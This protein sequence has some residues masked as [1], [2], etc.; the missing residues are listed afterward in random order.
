MAKKHPVTLGV[1]CL[2]R[3]TYD[4]QAAGEIYQK[5]KDDLRKIEAVNWVFIEELVIEVDEARSAA[6]ALAAKN[7]DGFVC[8]SGTFHL[9]HLVLEIEK[10]LHKP[11]LL[12]AW[13]ELPYNGGKIR[14]NSLCGLNLNASNL[15]KACVRN[16]HMC[17]ANKID[18][19]W[20]D[21]VR[22][23]ARFKTARVGLIGF[24]AHGFFNLGV[25]DLNVYREMG[26]LIDHYELADVWNFPIGSV[27]I[28]ARKKQLLATFDVSG[29][30]EDQVEKV[31]ELSAKLNA[32]LD[33]NK[34]TT[35]SVRCWP[36]FAAG[37]GVSPCAAMSLLQSEDRI[38]ACEGDI[39]G[40]LSMLAHQTIGAE[41]PYLFDFSQVN[42][43]E[44]FALFWHC[45]VAP[46]NLWDGKCVRS[47]DTYFAG[48]KGVT[49]DFVLKSGELSILRIDSAG[50]EYRLFLQKAQAVPMPKDLKGTY[51]KA[52]FERPVREVV[53]KVIE[54]GIAHHASVVYGNFIEPLRMLAKIQGWK[55]IE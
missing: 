49:A 41:T 8:I 1:V 23:L 17:L 45:G 55:V 52:V 9:G 5:V 28:E 27:E 2:A 12:W 48:G 40:A 43:Q 10:V 33:A 25:Y 31:A 30:T 47:L 21:A 37:F 16:Y 36:E 39:E 24:R 6:E 15:Y 32:F 22:I 34:L 20:I 11:I 19:N 18:Q 51:M 14:L 4:W 3:K 35:L 54:N 44:N 46:C 13:D 29:I 38:L 42:F 50:T 7:V 26:I 53:E